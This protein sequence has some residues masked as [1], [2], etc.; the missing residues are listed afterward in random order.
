MKKILFPIIM[1]Y[2]TMN[3]SA[4]ENIS[5]ILLRCDDL[6][7]CHS[8]NMAF[9]EVFDS[10]IP[11]SASTLFVSPWY[12]EAVEIL[13]SYPEVSVGVHLAL[14]SEW[15]NYKWGPVLGKEAVPSLVDSN[16][17]FYH[18][19]ELFL[20]HNPQI[21]EVEKELRAQIERAIQSGIRID[22]LDAHMNTAVS[23]PELINLVFLLAEEY[24]L[25]ISGT[26]NE[27]HLEVY[28]V[29]YTEKKNT[30]LAKI[31]TLK[32]GINYLMVVHLGKDVP[33]LQAF[34][35]LN[36]GGLTDVSKH[37]QAIL[38]MVIS[39]EFRERIR[40]NNLTLVSYREFIKS[41]KPVVP[42]SSA[43]EYQ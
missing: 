43:N 7:M 27:E 15:K 5:I 33:E 42:G 18:S 17:Y 26:Y 8:V 35:D 41:K 19:T 14:T 13:H 37:R 6:G 31:D 21:D 22:Y 29:P 28:S 1:I 40:S 20:A 23:T 16:G 34:E 32:K 12:Q 24:H 4:Q 25:G 11:V 2:Q 39:E 36:T 38:D 30:M 10:R 3:L 9:K